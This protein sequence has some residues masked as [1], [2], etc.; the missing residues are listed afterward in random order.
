MNV[1]GQLG[2]P[3]ALGGPT[4]IKIKAALSLPIKS[5]VTVCH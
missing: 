3:A 5:S 4:P 2:E 1:N